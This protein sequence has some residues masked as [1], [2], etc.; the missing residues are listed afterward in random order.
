MHHLVEVLR[1]YIEKDIPIYLADSLFRYAFSKIRCF[2]DF[3]ISQT[4]EK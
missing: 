3:L 1:Q 4:S 2:I